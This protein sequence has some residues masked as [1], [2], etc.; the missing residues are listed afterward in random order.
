MSLARAWMRQLFGASGMALLVPGTIACALVVLAF[1]GGFSRLGSIGQALSGPAAPLGAASAGAR[2]SERL[3]QTLVNLGRGGFGGRASGGVAASTGSPGASR[4]AVSHGRTHGAGAGP[5]GRSGGG[6]GGSGSRGRGGSGSGS[7]S[8]R[9]SPG[10]GG[11]GSGTPTPPSAPNPP[12][13]PSVSDRIVSAVTAITAKLPGAVG[14]V[15]TAT[16]QSLGST[17]NRVL[18]VP[19]GGKSP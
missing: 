9:G 16:L 13:T 7:G 6:S 1:A 19:L 3:A 4:R 2:A 15:A 17:L 8:G 5:G 14:S 10:G 11:R 18:P 12:T